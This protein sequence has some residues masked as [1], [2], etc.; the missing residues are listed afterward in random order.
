MRPDTCAT[1][2]S[3][4]MFQHDTGIIAFALLIKLKKIPNIN[5]HDVRLGN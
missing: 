4:V 5:F 3:L 2:K 1:L